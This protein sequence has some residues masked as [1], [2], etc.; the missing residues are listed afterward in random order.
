MRFVCSFPQRFD[1]LLIDFE[2]TN[3]FGENRIGHVQPQI[4]IHDNHFDPIGGTIGT[5]VGPYRKIALVISV[6]V[7]SMTLA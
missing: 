1:D 4:Q 3:G 7:Y 5:R 2:G 6:Y